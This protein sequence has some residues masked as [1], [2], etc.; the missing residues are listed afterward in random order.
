[1]TI[2]RFKKTGSLKNRIKADNNFH[3]LGNHNV[4]NELQT[5]WKPRKSTLMQTT[6]FT[7][8]EPKCPLCVIHR[9]WREASQIYCWDMD[10]NWINSGDH[11]PIFKVTKSH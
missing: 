10:K 11:D 9:A 7:I 2:I 5:D 1:M 4:H 8:M 6:A 3:G